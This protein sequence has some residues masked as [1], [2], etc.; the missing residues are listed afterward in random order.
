MI[1]RTERADAPS[2]DPSSKPDKSSGPD[3]S[4]ST[5]DQ[6]A[7]LTELLDK[8]L[9]SREEFEQ[10]KLNLLGDQPGSKP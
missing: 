3:R 7:K 5:V 8:G 1:L 9:L 10:Q 4:Q 2:P 6:L